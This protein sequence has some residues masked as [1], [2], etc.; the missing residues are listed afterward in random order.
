MCAAPV[1][2]A[3]DPY[4]VVGVV[5]AFDRPPD[6]VAGG[7]TNTEAGVELVGRLTGLEALNLLNESSR[8]RLRALLEAKLGC[9]F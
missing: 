6:L 5:R 9:P 1:L 8:P 3:S 7:A 4:A 2:C